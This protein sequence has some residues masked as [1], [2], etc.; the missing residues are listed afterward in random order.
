MI[1]P[2]T[3]QIKRI[4]SE[5]DHSFL[6]KTV[7]VFAAFIVPLIILYG[8]DSGSFD[9]LWKGR[10]PYF[11]FLWLLFLEAILGWKNLK[12]EQST[13]W[14]KKTVLAA[15]I[16]LLPTV[17][18]TGLNFGLNDVIL[19]LGKA[20]GVPAEQFGEWYLTH[21]WHFSFEYV[22]FAAFFVAAIWLLYGVRGLKS[23]AVSSFFIGGVG[24]FYMI[25]TFYPYGTFTILQSFVP[26][27]VS[28][29]TSILNLL[30]YSTRTFSGGADGLGLIV[31]AASGKTYRAIVSWSCAGSHSLFLYS[32][33]IMLFLRGTSISQRRKIVYVVVG[34]VGTFFVNILRIV[35][36]LVAGVN[37][38]ASLAATFHEFYGE[39]FF[40]AWMFIYL[41]IIFLFETRFI[42]KIN[43]TQKRD[44]SPMGTAQSELP[45]WLERDKNF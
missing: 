35:A 21:S 4:L 23:F 38:G 45:Q 36:I 44:Q 22:L 10:A 29:A 6:L 12:E 32:F 24:I 40:I 13:F 43:G 2:S 31:T 20:V 16:L 41:S 28:G 33:M 8:I 18:A 14:T 11:L 7:L 37:G 26:V 25:D 17:Y 19:E 27:T 5:I 42:G 30:G 9:Y 39:F 1:I 15:V 3:E 34:A